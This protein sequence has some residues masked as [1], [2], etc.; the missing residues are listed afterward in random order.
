MSTTWAGIAPSTSY[1]PEAFTSAL[2]QELIAGKPRLSGATA[3][4]E[5]FAVPDALTHAL[6]YA[7]HKQR[8]LMELVA[9]N[10]FHEFP[11]AVR[12]ALNLKR[13]GLRLAVASSSKNAA[14]LLK[15]TPLGP[16]L[17]SSDATASTAVPW[18]TLFDL[19]DVD[20]SGRDL[21]E[22]KPHP[23]IFLMAAEELGL[24]PQACFVVEDAPAGIQAARAGG[25]A[26][27]GV[28]RAN[29]EALLEA[30]GA[31]LVVESL[32]EV[33]LEQIKHGR[34]ATAPRPPRSH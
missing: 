16:Y 5:H 1:S 17:K 20:V 4:L 13:A 30:A 7:D 24:S 26:A 23:A 34:L 25:M 18:S 11:D 12:F 10:E 3:A 14:G 22:G 15:Q 28:A 33:D 2:Y 31:H 27:L 21:P 6:A 32:D 9:H 19:F 29:D 8:R